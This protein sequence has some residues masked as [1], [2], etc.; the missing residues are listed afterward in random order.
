MNRTFSLVSKWYYPITCENFSIK[1][2]T[3]NFGGQIRSG[4]RLKRAITV[5]KYSVGML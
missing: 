1:K 4:K 2:Q 3:S 5:A